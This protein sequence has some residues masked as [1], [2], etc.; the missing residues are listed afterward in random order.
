MY[1]AQQ[2]APISIAFRTGTTAQ[3]MPLQMAAIAT[4]TLPK[5]ASLPLS[6]NRP[7]DPL[8][9]TIGSVSAVDETQGSYSS[10]KALSHN[11]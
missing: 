8:M 5:S 7:V 6:F 11:N 2:A 10:A 1:G 9:L 4:P 3:T